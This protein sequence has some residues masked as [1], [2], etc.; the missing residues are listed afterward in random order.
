M[1]DDYSGEPTFDG[2]GKQAQVK[3]GEFDYRSGLKPTSKLPQTTALSNTAHKTSFKDK[4]TRLA[5]QSLAVDTRPPWKG[6]SG[7]HAIVE[8]PQDKP[9]QTIPQ[10]KRP[11]EKRAQTPQSASPTLVGAYSPETN[12]KTALPD[13][14]HPALRN[15]VSSARRESESPIADLS[16]Q[17]YTNANAYPSPDSERNATPTDEYSYSSPAAAQTLL[18][19]HLELDQ[20]PPQPSFTD[21]ELDQSPPNSSFTDEIAPLK[22][23]SN[24]SNNIARESP[25]PNNDSRF[26]WST[27][28][29]SVYQ[30]S[31]PPSPPP[32]MPT[33]YTNGASPAGLRY[34]SESP[35]PIKA[36]VLDRGHPTRRLEAEAEG[37]SPSARSFSAGSTLRKPVSTF[38]VSA[39]TR[40]PCEATYSLEQVQ[41]PLPS[42]EI[43]K[44]QFPMTDW[45][46]GVSKQR[47]SSMA[48]S[49]LSTTSSQAGKSL[50]K[51]PKELSSPDLI[52]SLQAQQDD[53]SQQRRNIQRV[54]YDLEKPEAKNPLTN[55]FRMIRE[56]ERRLEQARN[57]L[58]DVVRRY[59][60]LGMRLHRAWKR[61]ERDDPNTPGSVFWVRRATAGI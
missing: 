40:H 15:D 14:E 8:V 22:T 51:T 24:H 35:V 47:A 29:T 25:E 16:S 45:R 21:N 1:W 37:A 7:R 17:S 3:P 58:S 48:P 34:A 55:S 31:A 6:G 30:Q 44:Q 27:K 43:I 5:K 61:K 10:P 23:R 53:L 12:P 20:S 50:P 42:P 26:S 4:A 60:D 13:I 19:R 46:S 32:P 39:S 59:H 28:A 38:A 57:E 33:K 52:A 56:N 9:G 36:S 18:G 54:I 49:I 2:A 41:P 11:E